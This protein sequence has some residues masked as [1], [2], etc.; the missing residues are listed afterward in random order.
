M[1]DHA[2]ITKYYWQTTKQYVF[3]IL[4]IRL[5]HK[6]FEYCEELLCMCI[7]KYFTC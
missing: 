4:E 7:E 5:R 2:P 1:S 6:I 3:I